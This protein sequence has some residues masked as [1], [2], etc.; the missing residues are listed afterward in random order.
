MIVVV[1]VVLGGVQGD[2]ISGSG[3][4]VPLPLLLVETGGGHVSVYEVT[5]RVVVIIVVVVALVSFLAARLA[6]GAAPTS[7]DNS[8]IAE[9]QKAPLRGIRVRVSISSRSLPIEI[10][11]NRHPC[12]H[13]FK[14][15][16]STDRLPR[17]A[18]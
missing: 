18:P 12:P 11:P 2:G 1:H 16:A 14:Q 15:R 3:V 8:A 9:R 17:C 6:Y 13:T 10:Y 4:V 7:I 5:G